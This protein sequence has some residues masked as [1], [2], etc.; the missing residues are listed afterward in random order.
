M[1][2]LTQ[3]KAALETHVGE[4]Q[5]TVEARETAI[6]TLTVRQAELEQSLAAEQE[7]VAQL[8][9]ELKQREEDLQLRAGVVEEL[10][11][12]SQQPGGPLPP[13]LRVQL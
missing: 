10:K 11:E 3:S 7:A 4:L 5:G 2:E 8:Q 1:A 12:A 13:P 9:A 6:A